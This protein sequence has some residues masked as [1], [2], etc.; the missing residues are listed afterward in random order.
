MA[1]HVRLD[2]AVEI[3]LKGSAKANR[4]SLAKEANH[5]LHSVLWPNAQ[6]FDGEIKW[7][8]VGPKSKVRRMNTRG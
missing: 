6:K 4:R 8:T 2:G 7:Y 1:I 5:L 3:A